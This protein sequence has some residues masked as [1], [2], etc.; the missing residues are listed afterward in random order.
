MRPQARRARGR[1]RSGALEDPAGAESSA[2]SSKRRA[3]AP[4]APWERKAG[5][6][7]AADGGVAGGQ[8]RLL[9]KQA[10]GI[11]IGVAMKPCVRG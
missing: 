6:G 9:C 8:H 3:P 7:S 5:R 1:Q 4:V 10:L 11:S 2:E